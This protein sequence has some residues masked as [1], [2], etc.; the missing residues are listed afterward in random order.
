[1][2]TERQNSTGY[3]LIRSL[4]PSPISGVGCICFGILIVAF[5]MLIQSI[6]IGTS[7]PDLFDG[8]WGVLYTNTIVQPLATLFNNETANKVAIIFVWGFFGLVCYVVVE[9]I[10]STIKNLRE[11]RSNVQVTVERVVW[12]AG[13]K[14]FLTALAWRV[15]VLVVFAFIAVTVLQPVLESLAILAPNTILGGTDTS[16]LVQRL[17]LLCA[18]WTIIGHLGVVFLRLFMMRV[19]LGSDDPY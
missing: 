14:E 11:A 5:Y 7:L 3:R 15:G 19:R 6:T 13:V 12:H 4:L 16:E 10:S 8:E 1:M 18:A 2:L 17:A 9:Y